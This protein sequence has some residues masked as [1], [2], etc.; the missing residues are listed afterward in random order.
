MK[1]LV[2]N[3][4][5]LLVGQWL[6]GLYKDFMSLVKG[7]EIETVQ[8]EAELD[9]V[10]KHQ[11]AVPGEEWYFISAEWMEAWRKHV[12]T[13]DVRK[14]PPSPGPITNWHLLD[15]DGHYQ[16]PKENLVKGRDYHC[17]TK[18][19]WNLLQQKYRGGPAITS[20]TTSLATATSHD[21]GVVTDRLPPREGPLKLPRETCDVDL[22]SRFIR[23]SA[24]CVCMGVRVCVYLRM[25]VSVC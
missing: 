20:K 18:A 3:A 6:Q 16:R 8:L 14:R 12:I 25:C 1:G 11:K 17:V 13:V 5:P 24:L 9:F 21:V 19:V 22:S 15:S 2:L 7:W 10:K 23:P 4:H